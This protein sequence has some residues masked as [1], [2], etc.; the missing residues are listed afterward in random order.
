MT[1]PTPRGV[2]F[3]QRPATVVVADSGVDPERSLFA[4]V[5]TFQRGPMFSI[6]E[7]AKVCFARSPQ[8]LRLHEAQ[9]HFL[10]GGEGPVIGRREGK[11]ARVYSLAD[12][13]A[14][15]HA[16]A[17]H[18]VISGRRLLSVLYVLR[19]IGEIYGLI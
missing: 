19:G 14:I 8:W 11:F 15:A 13:E 10:V 12:L 3:G 16:L 1:S 4:G 18:R 7:A 9:G 5:D 17:Y 6:G 2:D